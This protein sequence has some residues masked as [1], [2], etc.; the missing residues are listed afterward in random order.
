MNEQTA[1]PAADPGTIVFGSDQWFAAA[2]AALRDV[3]TGDAE[4]VLGHCVLLGGEN[5]GDLRYRLIITAGRATIERDPAQAQATHPQ[6]T[7]AQTTRPA[8]VTLTQDAA[9]AA[10]IRAG[11]LG[12]LA[13]IQSG[14]IKISGDVTKLLA[15]SDALAAVDT[16]LSGL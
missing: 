14:Q 16:A 8:D 13:A 9:V 7:P 11:Q 10:K 12:A 3:Q 4:L 15:A 5:G 2:Q 6:T 1:D